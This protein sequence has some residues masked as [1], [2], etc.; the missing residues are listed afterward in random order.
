MNAQESKP[1]SALTVLVA[2]AANLIIAIAKTVAA[3]IT[4]AASMT[5]EAA[6]SWADA[7]N[8]VFL[9]LAG[10]R[11]IR[12]P[13]RLH[14]LGFGREAYIWSMFAAFGLFTIGSILSITHGIQELA[15]PEPASN[16][17]VSYIVLGLAFL[18]E[19][20]SFLQALRQA[21]GGAAEADRDVLEFV[22]HTSDPTVRAVFFEDAGALF[23][24]LIAFVGIALHQ[25][26]GSAVPDA[27]GS[28]AVGVLLGVIAIVLINQN[29]KFLVGE[30]V[31]PRVRSAA[32]RLILEHSDI[33]RVTY[34]HLEYVGPARVF[35]V[36]AVDLT[37]DFAEHTVAEQ[38]T[39]LSETLEQ[40]PRLVRAVLT[41]SAPG[42]PAL[43][44]E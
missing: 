29:R 11:A 13:D 14:P 39:R 24:L 6:H 41:L 5:A 28:I 4:G 44:I 23:G 34:L 30:T 3:M 8:G 20:T 16:F 19:G 10:R 32:L 38:L 33:M 42:A 36:A 15:E 43:T 27:I 2:L 31:D 35:L 37:G 1:E 18:L 17:L 7:G 22:L 21:R 26:T 12:P 25:I 9:F 40:N